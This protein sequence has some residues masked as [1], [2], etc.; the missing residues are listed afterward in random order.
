[1]HLLSRG[2]QSRKVIGDD[3]CRWLS[4]YCIISDCD[5]ISVEL[6]FGQEF[7]NFPSIIKYPQSFGG[8]NKFRLFVCRDRRLNDGR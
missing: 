3:L 4:G 8:W 5:S 6:L 2:S 1:M 7:E